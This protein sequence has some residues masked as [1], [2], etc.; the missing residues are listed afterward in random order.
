MRAPL[1]AE[2]A[3][4]LLDDDAIEHPQRLYARLRERTPLAR[5]GDSGVHTVATWAL[6]EEA[7]GREADFSANLTGVLF[8]GHDGEPA[9]FE[10]PSTGATDVIATADEP[11]HAVHRALVQPRLVAERIAPMEPQL[12]AWTREALAPWLAAGGGDLVPL[13]ER[14]PALAIARLLGLPEE[15]VSRFRVWAMMGGDMLAGEADAERLAFLARETQEMSRY[16]ASHLERAMASPD[17]APD[18]PLLHALARGVVAGRV[19]REAAV[20]IAIVMFGAG[21]ESTAGLIGNLIRRLAERPEEADRLRREP[22]LVPR[23]VE[24]LLRL[25]PPFK[26]HYRSVRRKTRFAGYDLEP[27]DRLMLLWASANRD[28]AIFADP[29]TLRFDR[30]HP[31]RHM[32]FGRGLHFCV[33]AHLARL[34]ARVVVEE[35]LAATTRLAPAPSASGAAPASYARSIFIRRLERL[36][37]A[38][39]AA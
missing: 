16:L 24:E 13:A 26:F 38:G 20:G 18:A 28:P 12:R 15:D 11:D 10:L 23:Y 19:P 32:G 34:E 6:V 22:G 30:R 3:D 9:T 4:A 33:G 27:G 25:D 5:I 36:E 8:R 31:K 14:I 1:Y 35:L 7:L 17:D 29:D 2:R 21:G 39:E 37:L